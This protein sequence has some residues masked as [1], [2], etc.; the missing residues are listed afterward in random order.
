MSKKIK[1][2]LFISADKREKIRRS[3]LSLEEFCDRL[4]DTQERFSMDQWTDGCFW[5]GFFRVCFLKTETLNY[6]LDHFEDNDLLKMG[7]ELGEKAKSIQNYLSKLNS[8][9]NVSIM[10]LLE[11]LN[12]VY[13][14]GNFTLKNKIIII[15]TP[16]FTKPYFIQG[17]LEGILNVRL[18]IIESLPD[19]MVFNI[20]SDE[21]R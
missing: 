19:R 7:R 4:I 14:W 10:E 3:G 13:G 5:I 18:T 20:S 12:A 1:A 8:V 2:T 6:L 17:Y 21:F 9:D 15:K 11:H 16:V